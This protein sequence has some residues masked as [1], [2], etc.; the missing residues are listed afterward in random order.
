L[1]IFGPTSF[2][3]LGRY[4]AASKYCAWAIEGGFVPAGSATAKPPSVPVVTVALPV[5]PGWN[6]SS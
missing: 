2:T 6:G 3:V 4:V 5:L 1:N